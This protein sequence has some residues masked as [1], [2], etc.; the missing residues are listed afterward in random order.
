MENKVNVYQYEISYCTNKL[1]K[2]NPDSNTFGPFD[3][4][5]DST[6]N[7]AI[8]SGLTRND[9]LSGVTVSIEC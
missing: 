4:Y 3:I 5:L 1:I 6:G 9:L 2:I 8:Y 7:T